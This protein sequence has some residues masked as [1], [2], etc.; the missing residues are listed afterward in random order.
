MPSR[1]GFGSGDVWK[2]GDLWKCRGRLRFQ[3]HGEYEIGTLVGLDDLRRQIRNIAFHGSD[4]TIALSGDGLDVFRLIGRIAQN[5]AQFVDRYVESVLKIHVSPCAPDVLP[6]AL[7]G[8]GLA[9]VLQEVEKDLYGLAGEPNPDA[10]F[11]EDQGISRKFEG[12]KC[13]LCGPF[14][15]RVQGFSRSG[16][17]MTDIQ[18]CRWRTAN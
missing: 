10:A 9:C 13:E 15:L 12:S 17:S 6:E 14:G 16:S 7:A 11:P 8:Y 3:R 18:I 2:N 1:H 5:A 4:K